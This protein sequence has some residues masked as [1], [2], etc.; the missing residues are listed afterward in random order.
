MAISPPGAAVLHRRAAPDATDRERPLPVVCTTRSPSRSGMTPSGLSWS[1][2]LA[3]FFGCGC[4]QHSDYNSR[5]LRF[6]AIH[7]L[8]GLHEVRGLGVGNVDESLRI[9]IRERE[10]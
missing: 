9:A 2:L 8:G 7:T 6:R 1:T 5:W 10:P 3:F 4:W